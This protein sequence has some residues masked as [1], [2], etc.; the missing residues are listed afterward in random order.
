MNCLV[1]CTASARSNAAMA[2]RK[3]QICWMWNL[4]RTRQQ[5]AAFRDPTAAP[6]NGTTNKYHGH[7]PEPN[8]VASMSTIRINDATV[9]AT[10]QICLSR[11]IQPA[12]AGH[13][14]SLQS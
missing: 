7:P 4:S 6:I 2:P 5:N 1:E 3:N 8:L 12:Y 11:L 9:P 14:L 10:N 13:V